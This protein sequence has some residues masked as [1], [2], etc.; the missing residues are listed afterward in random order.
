MTDVFERAAALELRQRADALEAHNAHVRAIQ[1][2]PSASTCRD[3]GAPISIERQAAAPGC[4]RCVPCQKG[5][6]PQHKRIP[7]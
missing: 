3:C 6:E 5:V 7:R 2:K 4:T 1:A